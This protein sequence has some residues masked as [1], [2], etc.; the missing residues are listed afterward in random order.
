MKMALK[1][2]LTALIMIIPAISTYS[3]NGDDILLK[4][5]SSILEMNLNHLMGLTKS[6]HDLTSEP[7][8]NKEN[9]E[10][11]LVRLDDMIK[12]TNR[13]ID[14]MMEYIPEESLDRIEKYL[15]NID[16]HMAQVYVD[17]NALRKGVKSDKN[18]FIPKYT[19]D[20]Y[21]QVK[22]ARSTDQIEFIKIQHQLTKN[23]SEQNEE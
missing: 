23:L 14:A 17:I 20:I 4:Y 7:N 1:V 11:E 10:R 19:S 21:K 16:K 3:A 13:D 9:L 2:Y 12:Q 18:I 22:E 8:F 15:D 6:L 5:Y